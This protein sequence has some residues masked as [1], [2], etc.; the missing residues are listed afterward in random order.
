MTG[1]R[2]GQ[3]TARAETPLA[4]ADAAR[5]LIKVNPLADWTRAAVDAFANANAV[6]YNV[7][8]D[9]GFPSIGCAPCTRAIRV[10]E[11]ER[12]GRWW[13][14]REEKKECGLHLRRP[15]AAVAP[16]EEAAIFERPGADPSG[17]A[18]R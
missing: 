8:H 15:E 5:G 6:P 17:A 2:A 4:E 7:L 3:S 14:E 1:L 18:G 16:G 10:G 13:W 9:R 12:A 11:D